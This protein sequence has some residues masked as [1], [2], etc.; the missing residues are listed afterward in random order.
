MNDSSKGRRERPSVG[1]MAG[2]M[3]P[4]MVTLVVAGCG[5]GG[6][7]DDGGNAPPAKVPQTKS[8]SGSQGH[9]ERYLGTWASGCGQVFLGTGPVKS[10][11][12]TWQFASVNAG[13]VTGTF[14]QWQYSDSNCITPWPSA[15]FTVKASATLTVMNQATLTPGTGNVVFAGT[16]DQ[17]QVT[18]RR[19]GA[20]DDTK[21]QHAA[22][23]GDAKLRFTQ[24]LPFSTLD[25]EYDKR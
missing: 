3:A 16:A 12:N 13:T 4:L 15:A 21:V 7:G 17:V 2:L 11:H 1:W 25:L 9:P 23:E 8:L 22:F 20:A 24:S 19:A 14:E 10:V 6:G 5:G 18:L